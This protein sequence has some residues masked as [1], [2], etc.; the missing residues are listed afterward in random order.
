MWRDFAPVADFDHVCLLGQVAYFLVVRQIVH[1]SDIDARGSETLNLSAIV[2][3]PFQW[4]DRGAR[5]ACPAGS[6]AFAGGDRR[7]V[8][9]RS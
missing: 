3:V 9:R 2:R 7:T 6:A 1:A 5:I 4:G 8:P